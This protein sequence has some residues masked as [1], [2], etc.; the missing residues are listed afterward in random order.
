M[1]GSRVH[2]IPVYFDSSIRVRK[3]DGVSRSGTRTKYGSGNIDTSITVILFLKKKR[4][5]MIDTFVKDE[6][7]D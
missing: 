5:K 4:K 3:L 2:T 7:K 1:D 6:V